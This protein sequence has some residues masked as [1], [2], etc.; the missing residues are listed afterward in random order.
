MHDFCEYE[1]TPFIL[2]GIVVNEAI[3]MLIDGMN[4]IRKDIVKCTG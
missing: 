1:F 4:D 3:D 2:G